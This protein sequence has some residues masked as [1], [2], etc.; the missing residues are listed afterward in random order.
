MELE[1]GMTKHEEFHSSI[2]L[3]A[4]FLVI[5]ADYEGNLGPGVEVPS[6]SGLVDWEWNQCLIWPGFQEEG[7]ARASL[8]QSFMNKHSNWGT[9]RIMR[10]TSFMGRLDHDLLIGYSW[11]VEMLLLALKNY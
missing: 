2:L 9:P 8:A 1:S 4:E 3:L 7:I 6:G 11:G 10:L 5:W